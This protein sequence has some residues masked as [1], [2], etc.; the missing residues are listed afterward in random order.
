MA[1]AYLKELGGEL[2]IAESA[3]LE[4]GKL[5]A[6]VVTVLAEQGIDISKHNTQSVFDLFRQGKRYSAVIT[7]CDGASAERC[8]I[9]PGKVRRIA[10]SFPDPSSFTGTQDEI[11]EQTRVVS[12][13][14]KKQISDFILE[15]SEFSYWL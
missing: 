9:F 10:W 7:V 13:L 8:P 1:E 11:L 6:N 3:G 14:I 4:P 2:F 15:A 12:Q 5:N